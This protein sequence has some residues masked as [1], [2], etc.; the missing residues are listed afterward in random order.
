MAGGRSRDVTHRCQQDDRKTVV[1]SLSYFHLHLISDATGETLLA[2]GRAA[3]AQYANARAIEHIYPLIR[4]EKQLLKVLESIDAEPGIVLYTVVDQKLAAMIDRC[5]TEM[6]VP[7]VS[8]LE[9]VLTT[10][11]S[12]LGAPAHRRASAQHVLNADYFRRI[13]ALNFTM[14][15][16]DGVLPPDIEEADVILVGISRT[17]KT[18]TSIYLANRGVKATNIPIVPGIPMPEPLFAAKRP[19]IVGL[20]ATAERVSQIRQNRPLGGTPMMHDGLYTDRGAISEELTYAR[21]L[22][23]RHGWP[24]ID[25]SR[26]SIEETA[27][28]ILA[29]LREK[30]NRKEFDHD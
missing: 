28:A 22:C 30:T 16:D 11:Q 5:C 14:E 4:T 13:D 27:A 7:S 23:N 8:V 10:F 18:P 24:I 20:V 1:R 29:L 17:S 3:A 12:Y 15:H 9:P 6:G 19:L 2:A 25:V 26:R 21:N